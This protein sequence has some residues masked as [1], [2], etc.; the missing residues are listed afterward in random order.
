MDYFYQIFEQATLRD[1]TTEQHTG[2]SG[3]LHYYKN[4]QKEL[5]VLS[6][7]LMVYLLQAVYRAVT[8]SQLITFQMAFR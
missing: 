6:V 7:R 4:N 1:T 3:S 5:G 8:F 2:L